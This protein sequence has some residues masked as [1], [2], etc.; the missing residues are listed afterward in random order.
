MRKQKPSRCR[1]GVGKNNDDCEGG[2]GTDAGSGEKIHFLL[3]WGLL[4]LNVLQ[5]GLL[6]GSFALFLML[7]EAE[8]MG[9]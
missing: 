3:G 6:G 9:W 4:F 1:S 2:K 8:L 5:M 7:E